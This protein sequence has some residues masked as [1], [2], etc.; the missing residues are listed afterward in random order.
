LVIADRI[1]EK[2]LP[3]QLASLTKT[4]AHD[5]GQDSIKNDEK[6]PFGPYSHHVWLQQ[7]RKPGRDKAA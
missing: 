5:A 2:T 3:E 1:L 7:Q 6:E 4:S